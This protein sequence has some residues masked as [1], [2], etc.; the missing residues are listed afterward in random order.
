MIFKVER[1]ICCT[2]AA[3]LIM[4]DCFRAVFIALASPSR[5][6]MGW[7]FLVTKKSS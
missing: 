3:F 2:F 4:N 6:T 7:F 5:E 1:K